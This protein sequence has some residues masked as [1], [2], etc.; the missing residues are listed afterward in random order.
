MQNSTPMMLFVGQVGGDMIGAE[1]ISPRATISS[2]RKNNT[3][4]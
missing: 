3:A 2:L 1:A 4:S